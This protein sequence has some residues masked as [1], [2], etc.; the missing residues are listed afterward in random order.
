MVE[1]LAYGQGGGGEDPGRP[2]AF[3]LGLEDVRHLQGC[4]V[5]SEPLALGLVPA[6][7]LRVVALRQAGKTAAEFGAAGQTAVEPLA[8]SPQGL[9]GGVQVVQPGAQGIQR[10]ERARIRRQLA[11]RASPRLF[12]QAQAQV[13]D[14]AA[15]VVGAVEEI[16]DVACLASVLE[17]QIPG[18]IQQ[19][20]TADGQA[21]EA[22]RHVR[23]LMGLID[24]EAVRAGEDLTA[25][26]VP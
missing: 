23:Q 1:A 18:Q 19:L 3:P 8:A 6:D 10:L 9:E 26:L 7:V 13:Q 5:E 17:L 15:Q 25:S 2:V 16:G 12:A 14:P 4:L 20:A 24:D 11:P 22:A 21:E